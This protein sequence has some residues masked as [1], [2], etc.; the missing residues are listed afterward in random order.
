MIIGFWL[1]YKAASIAAFGAV[2]AALTFWLVMR[3]R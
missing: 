2:L 3:K 1:T